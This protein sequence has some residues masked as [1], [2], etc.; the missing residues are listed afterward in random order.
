MTTDIPPRVKAWA[1]VH[2]LT[3]LLETSEHGSEWKVI[4]PDAPSSRH[5]YDVPD[6]DSDAWLAGIIDGLIEQGWNVELGMFLGSPFAKL[7]KRLTD[8]FIVKK[9]TG[10]DVKDALCKA[11]LGDAHQIVVP[12]TL[13][14]A[15]ITAV[16]A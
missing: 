15:I 8:P 13:K 2:G 9:A 12:P 11:V 3:P 7:G 1:T 10:L 4:D 6:A 5:R 16:N 14:D